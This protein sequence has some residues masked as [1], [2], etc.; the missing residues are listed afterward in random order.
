MLQ[1]YEGIV[2]RAARSE[3]WEK[4]IAYNISTRWWDSKIKERISVRQ[5]YIGRSLVVGMIYEM[6]TA[7]CIGFSQETK[8]YS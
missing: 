8:A 6:S 2:N 1:E 5:H 4:V 7:D 3:V